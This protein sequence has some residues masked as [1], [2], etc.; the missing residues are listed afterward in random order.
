MQKQ[1]I[2]IVC[3]RGRKTRKTITGRGRFQIRCNCGC[4]YVQAVQVR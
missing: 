1:E 3:P 2:T 4:G